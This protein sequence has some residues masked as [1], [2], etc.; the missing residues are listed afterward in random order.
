M[1]GGFVLV[2]L[3]AL[4]AGPVPLSAQTPPAIRNQAADLIRAGNTAEA[5]ELLNGAVQRNPADPGARNLLGIALSG[6]GRREEAIEQFRQVLKLD[7]RF[8]AALKNMAMDELQLG[9]DSDARGHFASALKS[10]PDDPA[11]HF[12]LGQLEFRARRFD[13]AV[14]HFERS[15]GLYKRDAAALLQYAQSCF[16]TGQRAKAAAHLQALPPDAPGPA[17]FAAGLLLA[18][19]DRYADAAAQFSLSK[20]EG[21]DPYE[22]GFNLTLARFKAG[23]QA[24][25]VQAANELIARGLATTELYSLLAKAYEAA[26]NTQEAYDALRAATRL[27]PRDETSYLDLI[28]LCAEHENYGLGLEI[29]DVGLRVNPASYRLRVDR[30]IVLALLGRMAEAEKEFAAAA[31]AQPEAVQAHLARAIALIELNRTA[32]AIDLLRRRRTL[33]DDNYLVDLHLAD[34]LLKSGG[35]DD[36]EAVRV[37]LRSIELNPAIPRSYVLLAKV[38]LQTGRTDEAILRLQTALR[39]DPGDVSA[40]YQLA[41]AYRKAGNTPRANELFARVSQAKAE[42]SE[43]QARRGGLLRIVREGAR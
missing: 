33:H 40:A 21:A 32:E 4:A 20:G 23:N 30:G 29:A 39:L 34:A 28:A 14:S 17:H 43:Q 26:G 36:A 6:A 25:A 12:G 1:A 13:R 37:L 7:P 24:A 9:R 31:E 3:A 8:V 35:D 18:K 15:G 42:A 27:D 2:A 16:E 22:V 41:L 19:L 10:A 38:L 5:I 11:V